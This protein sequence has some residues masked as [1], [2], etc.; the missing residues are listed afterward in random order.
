MKKFSIL[1]IASFAAS[2]TFAELLEEKEPE[3]ASQVTYGGVIYTADLKEMVSCP[4]PYELTAV[5]IPSECTTLPEG[6][7]SGCRQL[8]K[9]T[10]GTGLLY[11]GRNVFGDTSDEACARGES[12]EAAPAIPFVRSFPSNSFMKVGKVVF[13]Y[14]GTPSARLTVP[15]DVRA[16]AAGAFADSKFAEV[17]FACTG[18]ALRWVGADAFIGN[19]LNDIGILDGVIFN[20]RN[21]SVEDGADPA[22]WTDRKIVALTDYAYE[23]NTSIIDIT[24]PASVEEIGEGCFANCPNLETVTFLGTPVKLGAAV[25]AGCPKLKTVCFEQAKLPPAATDDGFYAETSAELVTYV[26][27]SAAKWPTDAAGKWLGRALERSIRVFAQEGVYGKWTL[28]ELGVTLPKAGTVFTPKAYGLPSGLVLKSNKAVK[29]KKG[30]VT[31]KAKTSWWIEGVPL[32]SL[33]YET[34]P[35]YIVVPLN[36]KSVWQPLQLELRPLGGDGGLP[37]LQINVAAEDFSLPGVGKSWS[38]TGLPAGLKFATKAVTKKVTTKVKGKKKKVTETLHKAYTVYGTPTQAGLFSVTAKKKM[39]NGYYSLKKFWL[40]VTD[41]GGSVPDGFPEIASGFTGGDVIRTATV[42]LADQFGPIEVSEGTTLTASG[43]PK[44]VTFKLQDGHYVF[45]GVPTTAGTYYITITGVKNGRK[46]VWGQ[47]IEFK[48]LPTWVQGNYSGIFTFYDTSASF[49]AMPM[50][51]D[52]IALGKQDGEPIRSVMTM[53]VSAAG[54]VSGKFTHQ[55]KTYTINCTGL[56]DFADGELP[57]DRSCVVRNVVATYVPVDAKGR[58]VT[59]KAKTIGLGD[60]EFTDSN[61]GVS[62]YASGDSVLCRLYQNRWASDY[63]AIG[64]ALQKLPHSWKV[65]LSDDPNHWVKVAIDAKGVVKG[66]IQVPTGLY[67]TKKVGKK[68]VKSE[69]YYTATCSTVM[70]PKTRPA[71]GAG[72]FDGLVDLVF[73]AGTKKVGKKTFEFSG[74]FDEFGYSELLSISSFKDSWALGDFSGAVSVALSGAS[75]STINEDGYLQVKVGGNEGSPLAFVASFCSDEGE[76]V[77]FSGKFSR[78]TNVDMPYYMARPQ[79]TFANGI[80]RVLELIIRPPEEG[81]GKWQ[82]LDAMFF[83]GPEQDYFLLLE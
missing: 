23:G 54:K 37:Q 8:E 39:S 63:K 52:R 25:F 27:G 13:G 35:A 29:N 51:M 10:G 4:E 33:D 1:L 26:P 12:V 68:T 32:E 62:V 69:V 19:A 30:K 80:T 46:T 83:G 72:G 2:A 36:G 78:V 70:I 77:E 22:S 65:G 76:L 20:F 42:G 7:L 18:G 49:S 53:T 14:R 16:I 40:F 58:K 34:R 75:G 67:T 60:L 57:V 3:D 11:V 28:A 21:R 9:V 64:A 56:S 24:I 55:G 43:L 48:K 73:P 79:I 59:S 44:G 15:A 47:P 5:N 81:D 66:T 45:T 71:Y 50:A 31:T 41:A 17:E 6:V 82:Q 61:C 74:A 38:V